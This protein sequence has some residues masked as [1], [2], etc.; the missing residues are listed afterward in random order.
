MM[1][2]VPIYKG[3]ERFWHWTQA[4]LILFLAC[5]GFEVHGSVAFLGFEQA[6]Q[7][8]ALAATAFMVLIAFAIFWH[9]TTGE[10][11]QYV[12]T[13]RMLR[14]QFEYYTV[15]LFRGAPHPVRRTV[16]SKLNPLQKLVYLSLKLLVI[17]GM[18]GSGLVYMLN[19]VRRTGCGAPRKRPTV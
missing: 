15:G 10:W 14:A 4:L 7:Y 17:P 3:F 8:H 11:R 13:T 18:V 9:L 12:P 16:L 1:T 2:R 19:T 5:T 6:V